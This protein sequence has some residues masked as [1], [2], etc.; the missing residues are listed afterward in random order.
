MK[1]IIALLVLLYPCAV[2]SQGELKSFKETRNLSDRIVGHFIKEEFQEGLGLA[3]AFWPLPP[4]EIDGLAN[5]IATQ[6]PM[7]NNRFGRPTG[8]EFL[9]EERLG[10]SFV[11]YYYLHRFE[12][13][14]IYWRVTFYKPLDSWRVNGIQFLDNLDPLF[15]PAE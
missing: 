5:Q 4:V 14:A 15:E 6:W 10:K 12:N 11:R 13:H 8:M 3:K 1:K 2:F 7:V 9:K